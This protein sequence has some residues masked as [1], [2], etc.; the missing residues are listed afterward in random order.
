[1]QTMKDILASIL[2]VLMT[3]YLLD[4]SFW[5]LLWYG[6][7]NWIQC[8]DCAIQQHQVPSMGFRLVLRSSTFDPSPCSFL[9][10]KSLCS[11]S[12]WYV[13]VNI[14]INSKICSSWNKLGVSEIL[15]S[16]IA[17]FVGSR[18]AVAFNLPFLLLSMCKMG[19]ASEKHVCDDGRWPNKHQVF[20]SC[21]PC[22]FI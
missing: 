20:K 12:S 3:Q 2:L 16:D 22:L 11:P 10:K 14:Q 15:K 8:G 5:Y 19:I 18:S 6:Y 4:Y 13:L 21:F 7:S 9:A 1:M 17:I